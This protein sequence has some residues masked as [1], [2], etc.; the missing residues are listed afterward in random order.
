LSR[1][2]GLEYMDSAWCDVIFNGEYVGCY[3]LCEQIRIDE[4]RVNIF[5]WEAEAKDAAKAIVKAEK[6]K[7]NILDQDALEEVM[8]SDLSWITTGTVDF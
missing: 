7:G 8:K 5:D 6:K 2:L 4:T 3:L 1:E